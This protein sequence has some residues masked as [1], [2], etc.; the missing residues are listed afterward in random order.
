MSKRDDD[1]KAYRT[2]DDMVA[3][4]GAVYLFQHRFPQGFFLFI[5]DDKISGWAFLSVQPY[6]KA[7][8]GE[9]VG[10]ELIVVVA[11]CAVRDKC[12]ASYEQVGY[13]LLIS[14]FLPQGKDVFRITTV[15]N[16]DQITCGSPYQYL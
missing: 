4:Y 7:S 3:L 16:P 1:E 11:A 12:S 8:V 15:I 14:A 10:G 13:Q 6:D 5:E 9:F 2:S